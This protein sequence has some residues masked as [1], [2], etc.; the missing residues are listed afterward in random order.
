MNEIEA[1]VNKLILFDDE[2][3]SIKDQKKK[4]DENV[5]LLEE[6]L[7]MLCNKNNIDIETATGG[8]YN[9]KPKTGRKL[10]KS[11]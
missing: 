4:L 10:K 8:K 1:I 2:L 5:K 11:N 9:V 7:I 6:G 3:T